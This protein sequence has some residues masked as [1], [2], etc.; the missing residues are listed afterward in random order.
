MLYGRECPQQPEG[1]T[2]KVL[3][4]NINYHVSCLR[5]KKCRHVP[6]MESNV[7][8]CIPDA[9]AGT[10]GHGALVPE[11]QHFVGY[12]MKQTQHKAPGPKICFFYEK[13]WNYRQILQLQA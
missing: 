9:R 4:V 6:T 13:T 1:G 8:C 10:N 7:S 11:E 5:Q 3:K 12:G 2:Y